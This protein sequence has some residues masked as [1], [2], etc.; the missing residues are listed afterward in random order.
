MENTEKVNPCPNHFIKIPW[1]EYI[2]L[3]ED[4]KKLSKLETTEGHKIDPTKI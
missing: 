1:K 3:Q 2:R 4:S